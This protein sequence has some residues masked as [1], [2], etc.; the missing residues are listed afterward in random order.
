MY[1]QWIATYDSE[2]YTEDVQTMLDLTNQAASEVDEQEREAMK[3]AFYR[4]S[5]YELR[6]W[7]MAYTME[8]WDG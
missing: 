2:A 4:S 6:F 7:E 1:Q 3:Q 8:R 5:I